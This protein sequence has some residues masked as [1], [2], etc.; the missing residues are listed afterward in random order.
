MDFVAIDFETANE[1]RASACAIGLVKVRSGE[2]VDTFQSIIKPPSGM[3]HF[4]EKNESIHGISAR[5]VKNSQNFG[6]LWPEIE[7]FLE[8]LPLVAHNAGFDMSV[9]SQNLQIYGLRPQER[10]YFCTYLL[11]QKS[12]DL[13]SY[14]LPDVIEH[15]GFESFEHHDALADAVAASRLAVE[16]LRMADA[17]DLINLAQQKN[18][19]PGALTFAGA[20]GFHSLKRGSGRDFTRSALDDL[21]SQLDLSNVDI[22]SPFFSKTFI[23][24]G[25][26]TSMTRQDAIK[27]VIERGGESGNSV[28][29]STNVLVEGYQDPRALRGA[30]K[31]NKFQKAQELKNKGQ[32]IEVITEEI[33]LGWLEN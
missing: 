32:K 6:E 1:K 23:F 7:A 8:D 9:L 4:N 22:E 27:A 5:D 33:F 2:I 21:K 11:S 18:M 16:L 29:K 17:K 26:L 15:L 20:S 31:S 10:L 24:T 14:S 25:E 13:L 12:I 30:E 3:D 19:K 28:T